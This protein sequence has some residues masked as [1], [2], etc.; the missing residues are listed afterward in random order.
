M[1]V[2]WANV[3][4]T[5]RTLLLVTLFVLLG[6]VQWRHCLAQEHLPLRA[7]QMLAQARK[8]AKFRQ[9]GMKGARHSIPELIKALEDPDPRV[10]SAAALAL[11]R[12]EAKEALGRLKELE[13]K[14]DEKAWTRGLTDMKPLI[15]FKAA[16]A[17]I[18]SLNS[19]RDPRQVV[20]SFLEKFNVN[21]SELNH[22]VTEEQ[23]INEAHRGGYIWILRHVA[24]LIA[25]MRKKGYDENAL[26]DV[27]R[28]FRFDLDYPS[29]LKIE[30]S[31]IPSKRQRIK[32]LLHRL[33]TAKSGTMERICDAQALADEDDN[34]EVVTIVSEHLRNYHRKR[35]Q[36]KEYWR[37]DLLLSV[38]GAIGD[39]QALP[40]VQAFLND[41]NKFVRMSARQIFE[42]LQKGEPFPV[43]SYYE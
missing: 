29:R 39:P 12:L 40:V 18:G 15:T 7:Q 41:P 9:W 24:D 22:G 6:W 42:A 26:R 38:L 35:D 17:R 30:L 31:K 4:I 21:V 20:R 27:E 32:V 25:T 1:Q 34:G 37:I 5:G 43:G 3:V 36:V 8:I 33:L 14:W 13:R 28:W 23:K 11:G 16:I 10:Q 19:S 2:I